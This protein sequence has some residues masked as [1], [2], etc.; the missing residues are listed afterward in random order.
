MNSRHALR[1]PL[2]C[3]LLARFGGW[4]RRILAATLLV[5]AGLTEVLSLR[6]ES[7]PAPPSSLPPFVTVV[8]A[9]RDLSAGAPLRLSD[10]RRL[11]VPR[12]VVPAHAI[13]SASAALGRRLAGPVRRGEVLTDVR[14]VGPALA[15][16]VGGPDTVAVPLR[17][18]DSA[19]AALLRP[20]DHV[21]VLAAS[22]PSPSDTA[23]EAAVLAVDLA[24][25]AVPE[26][27]DDPLGGS[28]PLVVL[29]ASERTARRLAGAQQDLV[30]VVLRPP[31]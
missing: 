9:A 4:P 28:A 24:V 15:T 7:G 8:A 10:M 2:S 6:H 14:L 20:G 1:N 31:P 19:A 12:D 5:A 13:G 25:L 29:A 27:P 21:D 16:A 17:L 26:V 23:P 3:R 18:T 22:R 11:A 30:T